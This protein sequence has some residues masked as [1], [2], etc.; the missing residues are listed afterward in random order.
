VPTAG[1]AY[2]TLISEQLAEERAR[3]S[4]LEQR[5]LAIITTSGVLVTLL[6]GLAALTTKPQG[7]AVPDGAVFAFILALVAFVTAGVLG[8]VINQPRKYQEADVAELRR[9]IAPH[10]WG[11]DESIG[12]MRT[13]ELRVKVL[14]SARTRNRG[15]ARLLFWAAVAQVVAVSL[16]AIGV[17]VVLFKG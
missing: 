14:E 16:V 12:P 2:A 7:Y 6:F 11:A 4:S 1:D 17:A 13:A 3:K 9:L 10:F 5:G 15:K 8:I